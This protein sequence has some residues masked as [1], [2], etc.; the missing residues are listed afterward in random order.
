EASTATAPRS[1]NCAD[2]W[3]ETMPVAALLVE[4]NAPLQ[5]FEVQLPPPGPGEVVVRLAASG[6][7]HTDATLARSSRPLP[8]PLILGHEGA[9]VVTDVGADVTNVRPG[10]HV[11]LSAIP[12]CGFCFY[13]RRGQPTLCDLFANTTF[14]YQP[15]GTT[16]FRLHNQP[17]YQFGSCG[18]FTEQTL[19][20]AVSVVK[21]PDDVPLDCAAVLGCA[22]VTGYGAAVHTASIRADDVVVVLGVGG[23]G[24]NVVQGARLAGA[25]TIVAID[26]DPSKLELSRRFGASHVV[27]AGNNPR[28]L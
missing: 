3:V 2:E 7:C 14:G 23:V 5:L 16:R 10:D 12:Q 1:P 18:T 11:V 19:L 9:G 13:C 27:L 21:I 28:E 24:L 20:P 8:M 26:R 15:D 6:V 25:R 4:P 17:V 22:V